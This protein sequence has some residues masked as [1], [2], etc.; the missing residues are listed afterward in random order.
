MAP[1]MSRGYKITLLAALYVAQ[2]LPYGFFTQALPVL[3]RDAGLSLKAI[4]ATSLLFLPWALKFLWAPFVDHRGTRKAWLLP[5]QLAA[6][7]GALLLAQLD[8][9]H[10]YVLVL[11]AAFAFNLVAACQD[12]ATDGLAVRVLDRHERGLAN[13]LQ[14]GA[15]RAGMIL[16]GGFLLWVFARSNW[17]VMFLSMAA[18]LALTVVPVLF[19]KADA[20]P[21]VK[22]DR[23]HFSALARG[24]IARL[25]VPGM[26]SFLLLICFYKF[27]DSMVASLV[28]PFL[29]DFG[30]SKEAIAVMKGTVGSLAS[31]AGAA[32]GG[33]MAYRAGRRL[34]LLACGV[35]Q[36][37]SLLFYVAAA[38]GH[39]GIPVLWCATVLEHL[40]GTMATV[41]LF[42]LM[43]DASDPEH[44]GTD[45]TLLAC[46]IV[47]AM[48]VA[49]FTGAAIAD[50]LGYATSFV[51]G[52][53]L[54]L[55]GC[56]V[57]VRAL[58]RARGPQRIQPAWTAA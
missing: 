21:A 25:R 58:D 18:L 30:L 29:R 13:G 11:A 16:G 32:L 51:T 10:G 33:W 34:T 5:L 36:S 38:L 23:P 53:V 9:G 42:T 54:S 17:S 14:V 55:A 8:L 44:A 24:W 22:G 27:G 45:Y 49:N 37:L 48:G 39:G 46:A 6:V 1:G 52:F 20:V 43:M 41:A 40:L 47:V 28:G 31:L 19:L 35:L 4:S 7:G 2:G 15:Y 26:L 50:A 3:L 56:L 12:I 57:L